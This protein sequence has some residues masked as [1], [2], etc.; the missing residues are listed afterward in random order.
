M[1]AIMQELMLD[2]LAKTPKANNFS[3]KPVSE[4]G[5]EE[6]LSFLGELL[7]QK[8]ALSSSTSSQ[9]TDTEI[10]KVLDF[11]RDILPVEDVTD[12][13]SPKPDLQKVASNISLPPEVLE[14]LVAYFQEP[15]PDTNDDQAPVIREVKDFLT[16][17]PASSKVDEPSIRELA[18]KTLLDEPAIRETQQSS[19]VDQEK[20]ERE[21][22]PEESNPDRNKKDNFV[23][24]TPLKLEDEAQS[25]QT[26][27]KNQTALDESS[28]KAETQIPHKEIVEH[29]PT[30]QAKEQKSNKTAVSQ[31]L[32]PP[33]ETPKLEVTA[34][35]EMETPQAAD[36]QRMPE[37]IREQ[38]PR[39]QILAQ[40]V[41]E[42]P[43]AANTALPGQTEKVAPLTSLDS[44]TLPPKHGQE[45]ARPQPVQFAFG[46]HTNAQG[47]THLRIN[48]LPAELGHIRVDLKVDG[49]TGEKTVN[50]IFALPQTYD[51]FKENTQSLQH[52]L[53]RAGYDVSP[54]QINLQH[55]GEQLREDLQ[56]FLS[57]QQH[58]HRQHDSHEVE[59]ED[60]EE[61]EITHINTLMNVSA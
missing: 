39:T 8:L 47:D 36:L 50:M 40:Q 48:L 21:V 7:A 27:N 49:A 6:D 11:V 61:I 5:D 53:M 52:M 1:A 56:N 58:Q 16:P 38:E 55:P 45:L 26:E 30:A 24:I 43:I 13:D 33:E 51:M 3:V 17:S 14:Q 12:S 10:D 34:S 22:R 28:R 29:L 41:E 19:F 15:L 25:Q 20:R 2:T 35:I 57:K 54:D 59:P 42:S 18:L 46:H 32:L 23:E 44:F 9:N 60:E 31:P 4:E 37:I